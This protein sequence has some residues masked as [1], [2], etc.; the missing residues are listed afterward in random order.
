[1]LSLDQMLT[2]TDMGSTLEDFQRRKTA[3]LSRDSSFRSARESTSG[4]VS[5]P[6]VR[7]SPVH[8]SPKLEMELLELANLPPSNNT[9]L[10]FK[11][12]K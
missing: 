7:V 1:M 11:R 6:F 4:V 3:N 8:T 12:F 9:S 10:S 2:P 5:P